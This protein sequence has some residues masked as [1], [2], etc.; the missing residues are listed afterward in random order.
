M[1]TVTTCAGCGTDNGHTLHFGHYGITQGDDPEQCA[2]RDAHDV[3][4]PSL[5]GYSTLTLS[6]SLSL[7]FSSGNPSDILYIPSGLHWISGVKALLISLV[8]AAP[9]VV[10]RHTFSPQLFVDVIQKHKITICFISSW[11]FHTLFSSPLATSE[12]LSSIQ[13]FLVG[14]GWVSSV[15]MQ[16]ALSILGSALVCVAYGTTETDVVTVAMN[17]DKENMV[18]AIVAGRM[19]RIVNEQGVSL[20][21][22]ELGE[23]L[24]KTNQFWNG[25][26]NDP[27]Q[28]ARTID[29]QGWFHMGDLGYF[30]DE[31]QLY[32]VDRKKDLLKYR[33]MHYTPNEIERIIMELPDV[34]EVC[35]VGIRDKFQGDAAGAL[36]RLKPNSILSEREV[37]D[38]VARRIPVDYKQLHAGVRFV[39]R[40]PFNSSG[41]LLRDKAK[42]LFHMSH[43]PKASL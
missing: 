32:V 24:I 12:A 31:G 21:P 29:A 8:S 11:E 25:Y 36:I 6:V 19:V 26:Y 37:I 43:I 22:N 27:E 17:P 10:S 42:E 28:T 4:R 30:D 15:I 3:S 23:I 14:G 13:V 9:R 2:A 41:K 34:Q 39:D 40:I 16:S 1:Q 35:V 20:G 7:S 5:R 33:S 38:H 18:G